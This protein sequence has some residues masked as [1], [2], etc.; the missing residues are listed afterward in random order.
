MASVEPGALIDSRYEVVRHLGSGGYGE[1]FEVFDRHQH[2]NVALKLLGRGSAEW[3]EARVLTEL[4]SAYILEV[5]NADIDPS[6]IPYLVTEVAQF[7]S[8]DSRLEPLGVAPALAVKWI[9][10]ACYGATRTH[11]ANL[12]HRDIKPANIFLTAEEGAK[13]GDFGIA[14]LM[15]P[16]G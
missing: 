7:G 13:L 8:A 11:D 12:I 16:Q 2:T 6:G 15:D 4:Q 5:R 1:V 10:G 14:H 3:L 9:R